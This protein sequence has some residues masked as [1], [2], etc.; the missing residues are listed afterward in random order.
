MANEIRTGIMAALPLLLMLT[1]LTFV[2]RIDPYIEIKRRRLLFLVVIADVFLVVQNVTDYC[3]D[4]WNI[5]PHERLVCGIIGYSLRP[6]IIVLLLMIVDLEKKHIVA[7]ILIAVN[8]LVSMSALFSDICFTIDENDSFRRGPLGYTCHI[9]SLALLVYL[10][11]FS[12]WQYKKEKHAERWIPVPNG[13]MVIA[14][15]LVDLNIN[16]TDFPITALTNAVVVSC[17]FYYIWLHLQFVREHEHALLAGQRIQVLMAQI[18]PHFIYNCLTAIRSYLDE[19]DKA[20]EV[21]DHFSSFLR[22]SIDVLEETG[23]VRAEEEFETVENY[24]YLER[25][26]FGEKLRVERELQDTDFSLPA[27]TVQILVENAVNHGVRRNP[28]GRGTVT[29]RS[30]RTEKEHIIEVQDNGPGFPDDEGLSEKDRAH[31]GLTNLKDRLALMCSGKLE[32]DS[33]PEKGTTV[34]VRIPKD[35]KR[36]DRG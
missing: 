23:N 7:W 28:S 2:I 3:L 26:R 36:G 5:Y 29:I 32:I 22:G 6:V 1:G 16:L 27:F 11:I 21:L 35:A 10:V 13:I 9:I 14:S 31:I 18:R 30:Y 24:L 33:A 17:L 12:V 8:L 4:V 19:P 20:E 34:R 15:V 25:E